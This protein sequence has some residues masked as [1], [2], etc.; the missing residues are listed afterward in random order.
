MDFKEF[1]LS[2]LLEI[3]KAINSNLA[4]QKLFLLLKFFLK[5]QLKIQ[6]GLL[7]DLDNQSTDTLLSFGENTKLSA[8]QLE[9]IKTK[10]DIFYLQGSSNN[11]IPQFEALIPIPHNFKIVAHLLLVILNLVKIL[12]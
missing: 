9:F 11:P 10:K 1:K 7:I 6:K 12:R 2:A 4:P 8:D 5:N 3:S